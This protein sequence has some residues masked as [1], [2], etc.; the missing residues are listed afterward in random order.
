MRTKKLTLVWR[1]LNLME[2][3]KDVIQV[4]YHLGKALGYQT[5]I[6][7]GYPN[8]LD[9]KVRE[10]EEPDFT[11]V[12]RWLTYNQYQRMIVYFFYFMF[13]SRQINLLVCFHWRLETFAVLFFHRLWNKKGQ[14]YLKLDTD[15]GRDFELTHK[16]ALE[17]WCRRRIYHYLLDCVTLFSCETSSGYKRLCN[18]PE[19]GSILE[20]KLVWIPNSFDESTLKRL[21][22]EE[23]NFEA[24]ENVMITVGRLG[25]RQKNTEM[26]LSA[27]AQV[28]LGDWKFYFIGPIEE[29]F[30]KYI[31]RFY[32]HHPEKMSNV[33]FVGPI[34]DKKELWSYYNRAKVFVLTSR[35]EG[36][37]L[38]F[39]E[40]K[41]FRNY[42]V[43]T[44]VGGAYD[45]IEKDK[46]GTLIPQENVTALSAVLNR[47]VDGSIL[48]DVYKD[49]DPQQ[50]SYQSRLQ[51][52]IKRLLGK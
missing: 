40:A 5:E 1:R 4:P 35:W 3:G 21:G 27:L 16:N 20:K 48:I 37:P 45:V 17:R 2:L 18:T 10:K 50:L 9:A 39:P 28:D 14:V 41:R 24:K 31:R 6:L 8:E 26:L 30:H 15:L 38:I 51:L 32:E 23:C 44:N 46:Y 11:F 19:F 34:F 42:L 13:H 7:C 47:I 29:E 43:S 12:R 36:S 33:C 49:F 25:T 22:I 52:I